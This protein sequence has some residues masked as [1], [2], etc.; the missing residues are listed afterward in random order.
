[1]LIPLLLRSFK[2][3]NMKKRPLALLETKKNLWSLFG[4]SLRYHGAHECPSGGQSGWSASAAGARLAEG[5]A[6]GRWL[7]GVSETGEGGL[8]R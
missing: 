7:V 1:M 3:K 4:V 5:R 8:T 6:V 2:E